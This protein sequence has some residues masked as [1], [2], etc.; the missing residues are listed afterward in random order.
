[1][2]GCTRLH[3]YVSSFSKRSTHLVVPLDA[4]LHTSAKIQLASKN[5]ERWGTC[6]V[7]PLWVLQSASCSKRL[8]EENFTVILERQTSAAP[9]P[10]PAPVPKP[11]V[12]AYQATCIL[13]HGIP[14]Q[15]IPTCSLVSAPGPEVKSILPLRLT[16]LKK[17]VCEMHRYREGGAGPRVQSLGRSN[18]PGLLQGGKQLCSRR[19]PQHSSRS[20]PHSCIANDKMHSASFRSVDH[21]TCVSF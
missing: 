12:C 5:M 6:V 16:N 9:L 20:V 18:C 13:M 1:M 8:R 10:I 14:Q 2:T 11:E 4:R 3:R 15:D 17:S 7:C 21:T 19:T